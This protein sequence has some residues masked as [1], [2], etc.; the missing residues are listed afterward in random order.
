MNDIGVEIN[1][2]KSV[3]GSE[4]NHVGEFA[5]RL[6]FNGKNISGFGFSMVQASLKD[7]VS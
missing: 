6:F 1:L 4:S 3:L 5:K 7:H 2:T